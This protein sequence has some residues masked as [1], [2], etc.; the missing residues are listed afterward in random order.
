[1]CTWR[2]LG[3]G[4]DELA[5]KENQAADLA[6]ALKALQEALKR[7]EELGVEGLDEFKRLNTPGWDQGAHDVASGGRHEVAVEFG[8]AKGDVDGET[9][10]Y[11]HPE[12]GTLFMY[13]DGEWE[14]SSPNGASSKGSGA[15][16]LE[17]HLMSLRKTSAR[18][19]S[20]A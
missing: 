20:Q 3:A 15:E 1:L 19:K 2:T 10:L 7:A 17:R 5:K 6:E 12:I 9:I 11:S 16:D 14:L 8:F 4:E 18:D 13:G